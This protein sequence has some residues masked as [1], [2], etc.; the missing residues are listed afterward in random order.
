VPREILKVASFAYVLSLQAGEK[1]IPV[2]AIELAAQ[3]A[4]L[5]EQD[6]ELEMA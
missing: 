3:E 6:T 2:E 1:I 5:S 4:S